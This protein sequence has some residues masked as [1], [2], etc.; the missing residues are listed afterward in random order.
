[1]NFDTINSVSSTT[2][3]TLAFVTAALLVGAAFSLMKDLRSTDWMRVKERVSAEFRN[4]REPK[5]ASQVFKHVTET[6]K[7]SVSEEDEAAKLSASLSDRVQL[8]VDQSGLKITP[9][10][11]A[12]KS[13]AVSGCLG[14][15][16]FMATGSL[17]FAVVLAMVGAIPQLVYVLIKRNRRMNKL[18]QQLSEAYGLMARVLRAGKTTA[19]AMQVVSQEFDD[20]IAGEFSCCYEE[21]NLGL[22]VEVALRNLA[23][24]TGLLEVRMFVVASLVHRQTGGNLGEPLDN[25][26]QVIRERFRIRGVVQTLTAEG[27]FQAAVLLGLPLVVW[28]A[29]VVLSPDYAL[30]LLQHP[31]LIF[32]VFVAELVGA[33][34]IRRIVNF[35][36]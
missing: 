24:R 18:H 11:L 26:S 2:V 30:E 25:L 31:R 17:W 4:R 28:C 10:S 23:R 16:G 14:M 8:L 33:I 32:G 9:A 22:P 19:E 35:D 13:A 7:T 20:P 6:A 29:M 5:T 21:Q 12:W 36:F 34:W 3:A 27:R 15:L 1:M